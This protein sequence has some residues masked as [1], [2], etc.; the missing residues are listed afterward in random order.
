MENVVFREKSLFL[1]NRVP[2]AVLDPTWANLGAQELQNG[3]QKAPKTGPKIDQKNDQKNDA[4]FDRFW[5]Q[6]GA[7]GTLKPEQLRNGKRRN[8]L[9]KFDKASPRMT[10][11]TMVLQNATSILLL[12][13]YYTTTILLLT[14]TT[15]LLLYYY[16]TTLLLLYYCQN[17]AILLLY[18]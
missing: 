3:A 12:Y 17:T 1:K 11:A 4:I 10:A 14:T 8:K 18:S 2:R 13:H 5:S 7:Q 9:F 15:M 6:N 16:Y